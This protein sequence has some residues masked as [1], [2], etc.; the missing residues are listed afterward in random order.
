ME[1]VMNNSLPTENK[2]I[3]AKLNA[4]VDKIKNKLLTDDI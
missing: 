2:R 3:T 1:H 4:C